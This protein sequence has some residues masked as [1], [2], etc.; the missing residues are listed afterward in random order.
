ML[1]ILELNFIYVIAGVLTSIFVIIARFIAVTKTIKFLE[2]HD[3]ETFTD[4]SLPIL[5]WGGMR[6]TISFAMVM[7][8]PMSPARDVMLAITF[9]VVASSIFIQGLTMESVIKRALPK[10]TAEE[11]APK[12]KKEKAEDE[13]PQ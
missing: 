3:M 10:A 9:I 11:R 12:P 4:G 2:K 8:L 1:V 7:M 6:G 13:L 5:V